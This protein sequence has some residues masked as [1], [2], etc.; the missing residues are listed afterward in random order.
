MDKTVV[1]FNADTETIECTFKGHQ[2]RVNAVVLH[3]SIDICVSGSQ[4][5]QVRIW[6]KS[7]ESAVHVVDVHDK[8]VTD[9]SL[10]PSGDY[11]LSGSEDCTWAFV[12]L[13]SGRALT[14]VWLAFDATF[15]TNFVL[16][17]IRQGCEH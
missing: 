10:H 9:I 16:D 11:L 6:N 2:K 14:K 7:S 1:L 3:P 15:V 4:D 8:A 13:H 17:Q 5:S 12:D